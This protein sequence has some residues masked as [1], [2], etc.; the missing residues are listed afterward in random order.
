LTAHCRIIVTI[1]P[2]TLMIAGMNPHPDTTLILVVVVPYMFHLAPLL[3]W[4]S[5]YGG[6]GRIVQTKYPCIHVIK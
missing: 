1:A 3:L 4:F 2:S 6:V 5:M